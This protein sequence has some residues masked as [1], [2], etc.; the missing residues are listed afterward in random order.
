MR[1]RPIAGTAV[2]PLAT[3]LRASGELPGAL[4]QAVRVERVEES[5][6]GAADILAAVSSYQ[7]QPAID[8]FMRAGGAGVAAQL[9]C[10]RWCAE[11]RVV[12]AQRGQS[13]AMS[14]NRRVTHNPSTTT[15][16]RLC[17]HHHHRS[18]HVPTLCG[19]ILCWSHRGV[20]QDA[21]GRR[22]PDVNSMTP[23]PPRSTL[24]SYKLLGCWPSAARRR[25]LACCGTP[26]HWR[27]CSLGSVP[28][29]SASCVVR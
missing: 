19:L 7:K 17:H 4:D 28:T 5:C 23:A 25:A 3:A 16:N 22:V 20:G 15:T 6:N 13:S 24:G 9:G 21:A 14:A 18:K 8:S 12:S 1:L 27:R 29:P 11:E 10:W 2:S 26:L